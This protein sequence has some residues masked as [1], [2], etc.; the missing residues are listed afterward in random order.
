M[1]TSAASVVD[2]LSELREESELSWARVEAAAGV[3][4]AGGATDTTTW[5]EAATAT[6][7]VETVPSEVVLMSSVGTGTVVTPTP[8]PSA[9]GDGAASPAAGFA[10]AEAAS[11]ATDDEATEET[12]ATDEAACDAAHGIVTMTVWVTVAARAVIVVVGA[13]PFSKTVVVRNCS[14]LSPC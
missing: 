14:C 7:V 8:L 11:E 1:D 3:E 5:D 12:A 9:L 2:E 13:S 4:M 6:D 10:T